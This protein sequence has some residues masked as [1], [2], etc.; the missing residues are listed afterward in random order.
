MEKT[1]QL[2]AE[3]EL[4][5]GNKGF[6]KVAVVRE[7]AEKESRLRKKLGKQLKRKLSKTEM[8]SNTYGKRWQLRRMHAAVEKDEKDKKII[9]ISL[10]IGM[11]LN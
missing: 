6:Q 2:Q 1:K 4:E 5:I 10:S 7:Q 11:S 3:L 8:S 9:E